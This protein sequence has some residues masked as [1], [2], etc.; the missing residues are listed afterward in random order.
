MV[1]TTDPTVGPTQYTVIKPWMRKFSVPLIKISKKWE[2][3]TRQH[4]PMMRWK[5][6]DLKCRMDFSI[7]LNFFFVETWGIR[8]LTTSGPKARA[9]FILR[10]TQ[11]R[12]VSWLSECGV[13]PARKNCLTHS[14][15][16]VDHTKQM[17]GKENQSD[18]TWS[19]WSGTMFFDGNCIRRGIA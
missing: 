8:K 15:S 11:K 13:H 19:E 12:L 16:S 2:T 5:W 17:G 10:R 7:V 4:T 6:S 3:T 9:E 14:C 18:G 1:A